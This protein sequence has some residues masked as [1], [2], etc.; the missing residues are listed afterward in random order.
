MKW[1]ARFTFVVVLATALAVV[2]LAAQTPAQAAFIA[3]ETVEE[4]TKTSG[5]IGTFARRAGRAWRGLK[6]LV[7]LN[8]T[9][10]TG[11]GG[12]TFA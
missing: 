8:D 11:G 6:N 1:L 2:G 7:G 5:F 12:S 4:T 3:D 9:D 10:G